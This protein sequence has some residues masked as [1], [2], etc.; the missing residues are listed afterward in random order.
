MLGCHSLTSA[1]KM[2][3][4][5]QKRITILVDRIPDHRASLAVSLLRL[6]RYLESKDSREFR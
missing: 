1:M 4:T 6:L 3:S 5:A 2:Q